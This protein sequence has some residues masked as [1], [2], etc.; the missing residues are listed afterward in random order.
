MS[1]ASNV[2]DPVEAAHDGISRSKHLIASTLDDLTQHHSWLE[3]YHREERRR[4]QRLRRQDALRRLER[5]RQRATFLLRRFAVATYAAARVT[6]LFLVRNGTAFAVWAAPRVH[7]L[8][9][10]TLRFLSDGADWAW[11]TARVLARKGY[12]GAE[13]AFV[14]EKKIMHMMRD[15]MRNDREEAL[16]EC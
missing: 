5:K 12:N 3:S 15:E 7:A 14:W 11:D 13:T 8:A 6:T 4:A 16:Q 1:G 10:V 9:L 2:L